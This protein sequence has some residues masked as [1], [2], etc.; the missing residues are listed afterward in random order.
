M[1]L[2]YVYTIEFQK[3][4]LP[5]AHILII[6]R[7][8]ATHRDTVEYDRIVC[9][10]LPNPVLQPRLHAIVKRCMI[11]GPCGVAKKSA[12]CLRDGR[13]S[14]RFPKAFSAVTTNTEDGYLVYRRRDNGRVVNAGGAQVDNRW[15][16]PY[17]PCLLL[18]FNAHINVEICSTVIA[19]RYL[20]KYVYKG[21]DRVIIE[22]KAGGENVNTAEVKSVNEISEYLEGG[23]CI[24]LRRV[25]AFLRMSYMP[26]CHTCYG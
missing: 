10:E 14:K 25:I 22:F 21:H 6:L 16:V 15:V 3:R 7:D 17:N 23:M 5:H 18:K 26:I 19:V 8:T 12:P 1:P 20:Y 4:S 2:G 24:L 9:A 11:H 13:C